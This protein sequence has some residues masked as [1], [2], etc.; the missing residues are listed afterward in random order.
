MKGFLGIDTSNYTTSVAFCSDDGELFSKRKLL[1]VKEGACGIRQSDAV[2]IH[3]KTLPALSREL[4]S[5]IDSPKIEAVGVSG[6]PRR[7]SGSYMPCFLAGVSVA[8]STAAFLKVPLYV[9]SHQEGHLAAAAKGSGMELEGDF[10]AFHLSGG[11]LELLE[12]KGK[13][14]E[15]KL[16]A[17]SADIT[18]GQLIDR[19]GVKM[20]LKFPCGAELEELAIKSTAKFKV[21]IPFRDSKVSI[22]GL[23]NSFDKLLKSGAPYEDCAAFVFECVISTVEKMISGRE[24]EKI[25]FM[26]GVSSSRLMKSRL[27]RDGDRFFASGEYSC[28]NAMGI[29]LLARSAFLSGKDGDG[30]DFIIKH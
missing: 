12:V 4:F 7:A 27:F 26:G 2:F 28:D 19:C 30:L 18:T 6:F 25:L 13:S 10:L 8:A 11:T 20:G 22:A 16:L 21:N 17:C 29:A 15:E 1:E 14:L 24:Q 9:F 5:S 3:T 23:E